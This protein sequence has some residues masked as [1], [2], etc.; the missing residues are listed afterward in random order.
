LELSSTKILQNFFLNSLPV[1]RTSPSEHILKKKFQKN[2]CLE[3]VI[4]LEK[5]PKIT[6]TS[7]KLFSDAGS[8]GFAGGQQLGQDGN[9]N[10][11]LF[12]FILC[13][14]NTAW[15]LLFKPLE[16][17]EKEEIKKELQVKWKINL[18][19]NILILVIQCWMD[20]KCREH[21]RNL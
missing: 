1:T 5:K 8:A 15:T 12:I 3:V 17:G 7:L 19:V 20:G 9:F 21:S 10:Y 16:N 14:W 2:Y 6:T 4:H 18:K 13:E 11:A